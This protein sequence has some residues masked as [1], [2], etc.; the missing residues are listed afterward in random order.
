MNNKKLVVGCT[1]IN[2]LK[3]MAVCCSLSIL[4][5]YGILCVC[6]CFCLNK[7]IH[8]KAEHVSE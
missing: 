5:Y 7:K 6:V 1:D 4:C 3:L 8:S 2:I